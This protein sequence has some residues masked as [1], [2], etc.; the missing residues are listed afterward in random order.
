MTP[1][2]TSRHEDHLDHL[3]E[4]APRPAQRLRFTLRSP[5]P[6][7]GFDYEG[8]TFC[9]DG[10]AGPGAEFSADVNWP[11]C[12]PPAVGDVVWLG[13]TMYRVAE[14][15]WQ[16]PQWPTPGNPSSD[17]SGSPLVALIVDRLTAPAPGPAASQ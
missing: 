8:L 9:T 3:R 7:G 12:C 15:S 6:D 5:G 4:A 17:W 11:W 14:R 16:P 13:G 2:A 1:P 10:T